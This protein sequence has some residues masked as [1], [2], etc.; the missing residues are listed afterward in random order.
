L[1]LS[2]LG[3]NPDDHTEGRRE[4]LLAALKEQGENFVRCGLRNLA[5]SGSRQAR[6][7]IR[8]DLDWMRTL[9]P[10]PPRWEG[11]HRL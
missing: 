1:S 4:A 8:A 5:K 2:T 10:Q 6:K 7:T 11:S 9:A 3:Y